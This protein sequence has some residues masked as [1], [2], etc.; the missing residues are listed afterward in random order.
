MPVLWNARFL[1]PACAERVLWQ[2]H[3]ALQLASM[4]WC[5]TGRHSSVCF[6]A[7][8]ELAAPAPRQRH[9]PLK[10]FADLGTAAQHVQL[11]QRVRGSC[12]WGSWGVGACCAK[13]RWA[14]ASQAPSPPRWCTVGTI[15]G[16]QHGFGN[17]REAPMMPML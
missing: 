16:R 4:E 8:G 15:S 7:A 10:L 2:S 13:E 3:C 9:T 5:F 11:L 17:C 12:W 14:H 1:Q 6:G